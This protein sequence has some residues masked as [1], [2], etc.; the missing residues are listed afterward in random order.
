VDSF[1][2]LAEFKREI[3]EFV[4]YIKSSPPAAGFQEVLYPG[5]IEWRTEQKRRREGIFVE[6]ETW[7]AIEGLIRDYGLESLIG[8]P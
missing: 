8:Q 5:E 4:R 2:P 3:G 7:K 1:R 6:E